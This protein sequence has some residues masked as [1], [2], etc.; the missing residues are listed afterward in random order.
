[1]MRNWGFG[2]AAALVSL[3]A[4]APA[5]AQTEADF[6]KALAGKWQVVDSRY[7]SGNTSCQITLAEE[8]AAKAGRYELSKTGCAAELELATSWGIDQGQMSLFSTDDS[9]IIRLGGNQRRMSGNTAS[10][11]PVIFE[12]MGVAGTADV[13]KAAVKQ[14]G[15]FY[16]GFTDK[17]IQPD[18]LNKPEGDKPKIQVIVNLNVH[19]EAREDAESIGVVPVNTCVD[20][21]LCMSAS[22]GVW[23]RAKFGERTGW[24]RKLALRGNKWP[25]VTFLNGCAADSSGK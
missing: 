1:M 12:R 21:D 20:A 25:V 16:A 4:L 22:D 2:I 11:S 13:L 3:A 23:C 6:V 8:A 7:V 24:M 14:S 17:C 19:A 18:Q 5:R 9:V 15:C 10:G